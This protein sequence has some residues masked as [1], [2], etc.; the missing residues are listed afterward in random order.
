MVQRYGKIPQVVHF[1]PHFFHQFFTKASIITD[2]KGYQEGTWQ[3]F[4][5]V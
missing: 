2:E 5:S 1:R 4:S 3:P